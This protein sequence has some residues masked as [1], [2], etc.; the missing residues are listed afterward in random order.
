MAV[1]SRLPKLFDHWSG[2]ASPALLSRWIQWKVAIACC[3]YP[4]APKGED[5]AGLLLFTIPA[6][7]QNHGEC[8]MSW[9]HDGKGAACH[10]IAITAKINHW[11]NIMIVVKFHCLRR[12]QALVHNGEKAGIFGAVS[13]PT[14]VG[15]SYQIHPIILFVYSLAR[16]DGLLP[17]PAEQH[18]CEGRWLCSAFQTRQRNHGLVSFVAELPIQSRTQIGTP[19]SSENCCCCHQRRCL[20]GNVARERKNVVW[21]GEPGPRP[22]QEVLVRT[23]N[24]YWPITHSICV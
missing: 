23:A 19:H 2:F 5:L 21:E 22:T 24:V 1:L 9:R 14:G 18:E 8:P 17:A 15:F 6:R 20:V 11:A 16:V 4:N 13:L 12:Y 10:L 3:H 7:R